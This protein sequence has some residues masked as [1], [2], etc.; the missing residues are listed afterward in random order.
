VIHGQVYEADSGLK[1]A[2]V[3][4]YLANTTSGDATDREGTFQI[5][6]IRPGNYDLVFRF[7]GYEQVVENIDIG[8]SDTLTIDMGLTYMPYSLDSLVVEQRC[9]RTWERYRDRSA[10]DYVFLIDQ[11][12]HLL[13][14]LNINIGGFWAK[15]RFADFLPINYSP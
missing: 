5:N 6:D 11:N 7:I 10:E 14:P 2:A 1:L 8:R 9:D 15:Y 3:N 13:N 4:V 12:G